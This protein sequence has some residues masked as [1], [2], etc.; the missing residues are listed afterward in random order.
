LIIKHDDDLVIW[1]LIV[2]IDALVTQLITERQ[3][4]TMIKTFYGT[5]AASHNGADFRV[6]HILDELQNEKI[7]AFG[8]QAAD[9]PEKRILFL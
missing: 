1:L 7:L 6:R 2:Q 3:K 5:F 9:E 8:G 4:G